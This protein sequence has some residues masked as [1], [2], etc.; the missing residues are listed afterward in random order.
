MKEVVI[1]VTR[2]ALIAAIG[3][4]RY[5]FEKVNSFLQDRGED[6]LFNVQLAGA[7]K[8]ISLDGG[9]YSIRPDILLEDEVT[10]DL[11]IIPPTSGSMESCIENNQ[12]FIQWMVK[13]HRQGTEMAS[14]CVGAYLLAETGLLNGMDC[15][16]HWQTSNQFKRRFPE[17][18]LVDWK[19]LTDHNGI[20]TSGGANSY[21][22]LLVYLVQKYTSREIAILTA[23]YFEV[24]MNRNNQ[25]N[26]LIFEG[27][28]QHGDD[29]IKEA[30]EYIEQHFE[31]KLVIEDLCGR[32]PYS[33]RTFQRKFK[34]ATHYTV[35]EYIQK[36]R[37]EA[38]KKQLEQGEETVQ[39]IMYA[40]GYSDPK[41]FRDVFKKNAG[42]TPLQYRKKYSVLY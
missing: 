34:Q 25:S 17:I 18:N 23:K 6:P 38:A 27:F 15:S 4:T 21:W 40:V 1:L 32:Y 7:E 33:R 39:E 41:A 13:Q 22:N 24:E 14:L 16:T 36:V 3:N 2:Q 8:E 31:E 11:V 42:C 37:M 29:I 19:I 26:F 28:K 30:Q 9:V 35:V 5:M 12:D 20:Y 10:P